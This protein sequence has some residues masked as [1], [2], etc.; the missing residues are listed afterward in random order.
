VKRGFSIQAKVGVAV[1]LA[2]TVFAVMLLIQY[3]VMLEHAP[4]AAKASTVM[5]V[6]GLCAGLI[7]SA[8]LVFF[9]S[10][11]IT[12]P[13]RE[14]EKLVA[15]LSSGDFT[16]R[17]DTLKS[18]DEFG[19]LCASLNTLSERVGKDL[20]SVLMSVTDVLAKIDALRHTADE[21]AQ[22][23]QSQ[24]SHTV[25]IAAT[26]EELSQ[27]VSDIA[28]SAG[29]AAS[30]AHESSD[31]ARAGEQLAIE[32]VESVK[33]YSTSTMGLGELTSKLNDRVSEIG[34]IVTVINEIADQTNLLALNA[35]IEAA[36]AG[37][38]G[39]GFAVVADEVRK[40]A[41]RTMRATDE[42]SKKIKAVQEETTQTSSQM[43][44]ATRNMSSAS[45]SITRVG[46]SLHGI[47]KTAGLVNEQIAQIAAA[48][49]E[50]SSS[51]EQI[52]RTIEDSARISSDIQSMSDRVLHEVDRMTNTI[53]TLRTT[54]ATYR[55]PGIKGMI[56]ELRASM[57]R[58]LQTILSAG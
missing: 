31:A 49:E 52:A 30:I 53:D 3:L 42:I 50:Q 54:V 8:G 15:A 36:R 21:T 13:L 22:G 1:G 33:G 18:S 29:N 9:F 7:V 24:A 57:L 37:E 16:Y 20:D 55:T 2:F 43:L 39:R 58:S 5:L 19:A 32:A 6:S 26:S 48:V 23:A 51:T 41:E 56:L 4:E 46:D 35:A 17:T 11:S 12:F 44:D 34:D 10:R 25:E 45:E 28:R 14:M 40:L 38:Q 27:S 47:V